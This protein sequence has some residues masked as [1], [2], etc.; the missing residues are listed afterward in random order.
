VYVKAEPDVSFADF[1]ELVDTIRPE[2]EVIS[3]ITPETR[4]FSFYD[5]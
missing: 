2:A 1:I 3:L 5:R 4:A